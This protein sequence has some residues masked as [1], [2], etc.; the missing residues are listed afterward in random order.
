MSLLISDAE[1]NLG[2][3]AWWI[4][5]ASHNFHASTDLKFCLGLLANLSDTDMNSSFVSFVE[6]YQSYRRTTKGLFDSETS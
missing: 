5:S 1:C 3:S 4:C 6:A 2:V